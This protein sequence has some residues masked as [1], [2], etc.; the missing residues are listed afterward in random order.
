MEAGIAPKEGFVHFITMQLNK[1]THI[2]NKLAILRRIELSF[3]LLHL[4][5]LFPELQL[6]Y[7]NIKMTRREK[8][9]EN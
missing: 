1:R 4:F 5:A 6:Q 3:S 7:F 8:N 2:T 9:Y